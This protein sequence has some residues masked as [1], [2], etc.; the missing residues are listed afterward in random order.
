MEYA[1]PVVV[2][3]G[4]ASLEMYDGIKGLDREL[5]VAEKCKKLYERV[6]NRKKK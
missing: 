2:L 1:T 6:K 5:R 3:F 4:L